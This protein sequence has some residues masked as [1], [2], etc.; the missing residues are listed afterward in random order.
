[1]EETMTQ[2]KYVH[3]I[4]HTHWDR[5]WYLP[6]EKH[7]MQLINLMDSL[8]E[9]LKTDPDYKSFHL[10]GQTIILD[11]YLQVRPEKR[12]EVEEMLQDG[13]LFI[14]PWYIL[15]DEFLTSSESNI[16][17]LQYGMKDAQKWGNM[18]RVGYFPDS[19]G[20]IGQAPQVLR[21][22]GINNAIFGRGVKPTG[23]NNQVIEADDFESP[24]SEMTWEGP[25]G[26]SVHGILFANWYC[27]GNEIPV[28]KEAAKAY[29]DEHFNA[30]EKYASTPHLLMMNGCDHQPIQT[31]LSTAIETAKSLYPDVTFIHSNFNDYIEQM[32]S[33]LPKD[34]TTVQGELRSQRTDGWGTLVNTAST[35]MYLK[36]M[37]RLGETLLTKVAE[38]LESF[39]YLLGKPYSHDKLEYAWKTLMQNHPHDSI[40][41][42]GV[43]E[44]H[45]NMETRFAD[46]RHVA[47]TLVDEASMSIANHVDTTAFDN[48]GSHPLPFVVYNTSG[49]DRS[50]V[51]EV[52][53]DIKREYYR[54]G[55]N[56]KALKSF[57]IQQQ[58]LVDANGNTYEFTLKD[59]GITF[60]Y[61]LPEDRFRQPYMVRRATISF[62]AEDVPALG[63]KTFALVNGNKK[64]I[65]E[66]PSLVINEREMENDYTHVKI[67]QNGS[68]TITDK[69]TNQSYQNLGVYENTGDIGNEYMYKQPEGE[70][71]LTTNHVDAQIELMED[72][73]YKATF[74][75]THNWEIPESATELLKEEQREVVEFTKR[76]AQRSEKKVPFVIQTYLSINKV[77]KEV[78]VDIQLNNQAKDHRLRA[79]FPTA[80]QTNSH[81][82]DSIFEVAERPNKPSEGWTNPDHSQHQQNF[83]SMR[84][85]NQSI[86]I[87]NHGLNEYEVL[88][89][90]RNTIAM[91]LLRAVGEMGDWGYF[92]TPE[93]QCIGEYTASFAIIPG[94]GDTSSD[95]HKAYQYQIPWTTQQTSVHKGSLEPVYAFI[96]WQ[97][98]NIAFSSVKIAEETGDMFVRSYNLG[99]QQSTLK[100]KSDF[101]NQGY[102]SNV[103]EEVCQPIQVNDAQ[104]LTTEMKEYDI[105]TIGFKR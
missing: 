4:S 24:Y 44:I 13:R 8:L 74:L 46:S 6:Y 30:L 70:E 100:L 28:E 92:P 14:G 41:G 103:I 75:I 98:N 102:E 55:V 54:D 29:W 91:T 39:A 1:M 97:G 51:L 37:N 85:E 64:N 31:D 89:D 2:N 81:R 90:E 61:E 40:C 79:L 15:Q 93:A 45:R 22:A 82:A 9:T 3:I 87:A 32:A 76:K 20:N 27:N 33:T 43:D 80:I 67:H 48:M 16:R 62:A 38:P 99:S 86:T 58:Q 77:N 42:C 34:I 88:R 19:F 5:E 104:E 78:Y 53:L 96:E 84:N 63:F 50:G 23:F 26:S 57:E 7:H 12:D 11:D 18:S 72:E 36:Q 35:R 56:K 105:K 21:Q 83:V 73:S 60:D 49:Y 94:D 68:Y 25:D 101:Y 71:A 65:A 59:E 10:D 47:E 17:N 52:T 69:M 66:K 95:C